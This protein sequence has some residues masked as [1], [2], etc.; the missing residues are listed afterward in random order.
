MRSFAGW[1]RGLVC[2]SFVAVA[3]VGVPVTAGAV[4]PAPA[5]RISASVATTVTTSLSRFSI[6]HFGTR[7]I[8][9]SGETTLTTSFDATGT[10]GISTSSDSGTTWSAPE[11]LTGGTPMWEYG[12]PYLKYGAGRT[13][14]LWPLYTNDYSRI[15]HRVRTESTG[16]WSNATV[17]GST[18]YSDEVIVSPNPAVRANGDLQLVYDGGHYSGHRSRT[19]SPAAGW[20]AFSAL[21]GR[22]SV[23]HYYQNTLPV[24]TK[25]FHFGRL[26]SNQRLYFM[27]NASGAWGG[28]REATSFAISNDHSE[29]YDGKGSVYVF[30]TDTATYPAVWWSKVD[31]STA[32]FSAWQRLDGESG[33]YVTRPSA[34][35]D[36]EG[37]VWV[38]YALTNRIACR[39][40]DAD[41]GEWSE[42]GFVSESSEGTCYSPSVRYQAEHHLMPGILDLTYRVRTASGTNALKYRRIQL[43]GGIAAADEYPVKSGT[44]REVAAPGVFAN[45]ADKGEGWGSASVISAPEHG[46]LDFDAATGAFVYTPEPGYTGTDTF[47]YRREMDSGTEDAVVTLEVNDSAPPVTSPESYAVERGKRLS[48]VAPGVLKND[49]DVNRDPLTAVLASTPA[50][51]TLTLRA[52]GSFD[53]DAPAAQS[54]EFKFTYRASDGEFESEL[55]T[56]TI[57]VN[58]SPVGVAE[59]YECDRYGSLSVAAPGLL[60][61]DSDPEGGPITAIVAEDPKAGTLS[62]APDG[63]FTYAPAAGFSGVDSFKYR[64][65]DETGLTSAP[66]QVVIEVPF[67]EVVQGIVRDRVTGAPISGIVVRI[68]PMNETYPESAAS[69][70]IA[71]TGSDGRYRIGEVRRNSYYVSFI[72]TRDTYRDEHIWQQTTPLG[73]SY[74]TAIEGLVNADAYLTPTSAI[75]NRVMRISGAGRYQTAIKMSQSTFLQCNTVILASGQSYADALSAAPLAGYHRAPILLTERDRLS[76]GVLDEITRLGAS[77]VVIVGGPAVIADNVIDQLNSEGLSAKRIS[78]RNRYETSGALV[79]EL[80]RVA[81]DEI[82]PEPIVVRG[83]TFADA[84]SVAPFAWRE[85]RPILLVQPNDAPLATAQA[86]DRLNSDTIIIVGGK[87]AVGE[88]ALFDLWEYALKPSGQDFYY[89]RIEGAGRY[90]TAAAVANAWNANY[91]GMFVASGTSFPD[92]LAGG[93]V[94]GADWGALLLTDP[95]TLSGATKTLVNRDKTYLRHLTVLGGTSAVSSGIESTLRTV[96]G[97]KLYDMDNYSGVPAMVPLAGV[98]RALGPFAPANVEPRDQ[99]SEMRAP[100]E[101]WDRQE[102]DPVD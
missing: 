33:Q 20:S 40:L 48:V 75:K 80:L 102:F 97:T 23:D 83:D 94:A 42:R 60:A 17:V 72:D 76:S 9:R 59:T 77:E 45:D 13:H 24:G 95:N 36:H 25:S 54:G 87:A 14:V 96:V 3:V 46:V 70:S 68:V 43:T 71:V 26:F 5:E 11:W 22:I 99:R 10:G 92:A 2:A 7:N 93:P 89:Y 8:V 39:V 82:A 18:T 6:Y 16:Q 31:V 78:G 51:G 64:V 66:I 50:T 91:D 30:V 98:S 101:E 38:F 63:G 79:T 12:Q 41:T 85:I 19:W 44:P 49:S 84:L 73:S 52:D 58:S 88:G 21:T 61:N 90:E 32:T 57:R 55:E 53:Y 81:G 34:T 86:F 69:A 67:G 15:G 56:V 35:V 29:V 4:E 62:L 27:S 37:N 28:Y 1:A 65:K 74:G 100:I 47:T